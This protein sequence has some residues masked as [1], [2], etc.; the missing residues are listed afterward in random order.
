MRRSM[1][2][3]LFTAIPFLTFV[4]PLSGCGGAPG[5]SDD[6]VETSESETFALKDKDCGDDG[7]SKELSVQFLGRYATGLEA[8]ES[9]GETVAV[10]DKRLYVTS[11]EAV[12]LDV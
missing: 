11:A 8:L 2:T 4:L 6:L 10:K 5:T 1:R 3:C 9:S 7:S 12:A